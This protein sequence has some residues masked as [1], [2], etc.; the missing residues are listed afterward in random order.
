MMAGCCLL[1][2]AVQRSDKEIRKFFPRN[3]GEKMVLVLYRNPSDVSGLC[4][5]FTTPASRN[6]L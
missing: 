1:A 4:G 6:F 3:F 2:P 5:G